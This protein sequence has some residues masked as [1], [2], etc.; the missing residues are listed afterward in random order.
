MSDREIQ[1]LANAILKYEAWQH[2]RQEL[3]EA[4]RIEQP[5]KRRL[6]KPMDTR[7]AEAAA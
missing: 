7:G 1:N 5:R 6:L 2:R 4:Q 3:R